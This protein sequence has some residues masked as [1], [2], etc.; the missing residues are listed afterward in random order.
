MNVVT[1]EHRRDIIDLMDRM[2]T[3]LVDKMAFY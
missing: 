2:E 3:S 1:K